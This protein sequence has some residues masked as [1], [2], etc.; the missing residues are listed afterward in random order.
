MHR[1]VRSRPA[2]SSRSGSAPEDAQ[3]GAA[4]RRAAEGLRAPAE[5]S[6]RRWAVWPGPEGG[7]G[8]ACEMWS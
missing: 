6:L 3:P 7:G 5:Q 4:G 2:P 8:V 1:S